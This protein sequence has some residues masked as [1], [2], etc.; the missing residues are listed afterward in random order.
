MLAL[1]C[2]AVFINLGHGHNSLLAAT[3][4][5]G[6]LIQLDRRPW[7]AGV[8]TDLMVYK[9]QCGLLIPVGL[10]AS[11]RW[12]TFAAALTVVALTLVV[13][14]AF[15]PEEWTAFLAS[16][17][18]TR[19]V[20]LEQGDTGWQKIQSVF[21]VVR[22]WSGSVPLACALQRTVTVAV[23]A[24]HAWCGTAARPSRSRPPRSPSAL[25]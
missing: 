8:L 1:A 23:A 7:L 6:A 10:M 19:T 24:A 5:G 12:R 11:G 20:V 17:K 9:P 4:L 16:T 2:P 15:G 13:T 18:F 3:L 22:M 14:F 21:S 25:S